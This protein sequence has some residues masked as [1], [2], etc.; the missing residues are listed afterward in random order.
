MDGVVCRVTKYEKRTLVQVGTEAATRY[1]FDLKSASWKD[2]EA[3]RKQARAHK[4]WAALA[5]ARASS[6]S[7]EPST[8]EQQAAATELLVC[9]PRRKRQ[10][11]DWL[12]PMEGLRDF[13]TGSRKRQR[14]QAECEHSCQN[15]ACMADRAERDELRKQLASEVAAHAQLREELGVLARAASDGGAES[16]AAAAMQQALLAILDGEENEADELA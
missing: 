13:A 1:T 15:A 2:D 11:P 16:L 14:S 10:V 12:Q 7:E 8:V 3:I 4:K 6:S 9:R 5:P